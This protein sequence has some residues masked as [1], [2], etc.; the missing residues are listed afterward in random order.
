MASLGVAPLPAAGATL[1]VGARW[2]GVSIALEGA[3]DTPAS[4]A[5]PGSGK[6]SSWLS[7]AALVPCAHFEPLIACALAQVGS[8]QA[9]SDGVPDRRSQSILWLAAGGRFG[10]RIPLDANRTELQV[11]GDLVANLVPPV[12]QLNGTPAW[13]APPVAASFGVDVLVRF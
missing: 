6:V 11:R 1:G 10:T 7:T 8:M 12:L 9:W 5:A 13:T 3:I 4:V 2:P